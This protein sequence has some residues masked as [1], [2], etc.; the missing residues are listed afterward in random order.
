LEVAEHIPKHLEERFTQ[1]VHRHVKIGGYLML[2]WAV[3]GQGGLGHV[4][5]RNNE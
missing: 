1:T 4:N 3:E 5:C 2:S